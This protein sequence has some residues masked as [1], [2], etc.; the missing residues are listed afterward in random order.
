MGRHLAC[1]ELC[2]LVGVVKLVAV[3]ICCHME[4]A[5]R[6]ACVL[7]LSPPALSDVALTVHNLMRNTDYALAH[8][9]GQVRICCVLCFSPLLM[10][11][12]GPCIQLYLQQVT[13]A[14][15]A[16]SVSFTACGCSCTVPHNS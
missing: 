12:H 13:S 16:F 1:R 9:T 7:Q 10:L 3:T 2:S 8:G 4:T 14:N 5:V 6:K 11:T 15:R